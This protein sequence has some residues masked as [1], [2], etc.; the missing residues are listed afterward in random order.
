[1]TIP[2]PWGIAAGG[3]NTWVTHTNYR[4]LEKDC[5][6]SLMHAFVKQNAKK[7]GELLYKRVQ[8]RYFLPIPAN[9]NEFSLMI[10]NND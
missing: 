4:G 10:R 3:G 2:A 5:N 8:L 6:W 1:M 7:T 9:A